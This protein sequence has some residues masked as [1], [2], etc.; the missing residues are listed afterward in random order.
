[1]KRFHVHAA[2]L[3]QKGADCCYARKD[4]HWVTD[5]TG[6]ARETFHT[7]GSVPVHASDA[8]TQ[9]GARTAACCAPASAR[10][11]KAPRCAPALNAEAKTSCCA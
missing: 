1:M 8:A 3:A 5:P 4:K 7:L 10:D 6:I 11:M 2:V 9:A